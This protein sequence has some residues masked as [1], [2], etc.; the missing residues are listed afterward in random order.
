ML[1]KWRRRRSYVTILMGVIG[2][3]L[4][5]LAWLSLGKVPG[6]AAV[7]IAF[8]GL[9][10]PIGFYGLFTLVGWQR[11][12][13]AGATPGRFIGWCVKMQLG[14]IAPMA[15]MI[16]LLSLMNNASHALD[17][18]G[19]A[20]QGT[21]V[22][23]ASG[24]DAADFRREC[25]G[26]VTKQ[27]RANGGDVDTLKPRIDRFCGCVTVGMQTTFS[28][29]ELEEMPTRPNASKDPRYIHILQQCKATE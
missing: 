13:A 27:T 3:G 14:N 29:S 5:V 9:V 2:L 28:D 10:L 4:M 15:F 24:F 22:A 1:D 7:N 26:S 17:R 18:H 8:L 20:G 12:V 19:A 16:F 25:V 23:A 21:T 6:E 11:S